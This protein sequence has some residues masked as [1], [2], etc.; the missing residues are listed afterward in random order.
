MHQS[1]RALV[2]AALLAGALSGCAL[3]APG[4][5]VETEGQTRQ[6]ACDQMLPSLLSLTEETTAAFDAVSSDPSLAS[7][8][9]RSISEDFRA[10]IDEL[11]NEEV[12]D[13]MTTAADSLDT[14]TEEIDKSLAGEQNQEALQAAIADV[15]TDF[16]AIDTV[17]KPA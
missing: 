1:V 3:V 2:A 7:P 14:M 16:S 10:A 8:L 6:Q 12:I 9:L 15:Q 5:N 13:V 11:D 17:C 4:A